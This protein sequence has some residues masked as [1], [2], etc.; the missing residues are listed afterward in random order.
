M[1][2]THLIQVNDPRDASIEPLTRDQLWRGL[3]VRAEQPKHFLIGVDTCDIQRRDDNTLER[4]LRFG[5][6]T[7]HDRVIFDAPIEVRYEI[8]A[9]D[10]MPGGT[11][12][13]RIEEP[14]PGELF[15]RCSYVLHNGDGRVEDFYNEFRKSAYVEADIDTIRMIRQMA[16]SGLL[17][18]P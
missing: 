12:S 10:S 15:L 9:T 8:A 6:H 14:A 1:Q 5:A 11:L 16:A 2:F 13:M 17:S 7:L 18:A 3:V 4:R